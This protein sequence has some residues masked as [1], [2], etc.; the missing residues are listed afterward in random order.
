MLH[1]RQNISRELTYDNWTNLSGFAGTTSVDLLI[2]KVLFAPAGWIQG[3][4]QVLF[5]SELC[6][7]HRS[8]SGRG[9]FL[10]DRS[11]SECQQLSLSHSI[12][13]SGSAKTENKSPADRFATA[14]GLS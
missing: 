4:P 7:N 13:N 9:T 1:Q 14:W 3:S 10:D 8:D 11:V 12:L 2:K 5:T 6:D